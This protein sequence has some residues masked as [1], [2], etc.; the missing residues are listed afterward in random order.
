M[1]L[2]SEYSQIKMCIFKYT[3]TLYLK[4]YKQLSYLPMWLKWSAMTGDSV[5]LKKAHGR[6]EYDSQMDCDDYEPICFSTM[7]AIINPCRCEELGERNHLEADDWITWIFCIKN[8]ALQQETQEFSLKIHRNWSRAYDFQSWIITV[9]KQLKSG[10]SSSLV[11][12]QF[13]CNCIPNHLIIIHRGSHV[14]FSMLEGQLSEWSWQ[15]TKRYSFIWNVWGGC[16]ITP[17][18]Y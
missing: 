15:H 14:H 18:R 2:L 5:Q 3:A 1:A 12:T 8:E 17:Y 4:E 6:R 11:G 9:H 13:I 16:S 7:W 10:F